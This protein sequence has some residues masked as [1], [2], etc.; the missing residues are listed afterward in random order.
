MGRIIFCTCQGKEEKG[1]ALDEL[2]QSGNE[3][4]VLNDLCGLAVEKPAQ[5]RELFK[6]HGKVVLIACHARAVE[7]I[8]RFAELEADHFPQK[9]IDRKMENW[10]LEE[11]EY[12]GKTKPEGKPVEIQ[13]LNHSDWPSWYPVLDTT[14]CTSCGQCADFCLFG[15]YKKGDGWIKV[16][17]PQACKNNCPAC[18]RIC[19]H[20]AIIFPKYQFGGAISGSE[21]INEEAEMERQRKDIANFLGSDIYKG[22]EQRKAK[23]QMIIKQDALQK[24]LSERDKAL[25]ETEIKNDGKPAADSVNL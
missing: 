21:E 10:Q 25:R 15:V 22:L 13:N 20:I 1:K 6:H 19:P 9:I 14:R 16:V 5:L 23:R 12:F 18:A 11:S 24:A 17:N 3:I 7:N 2:R 8:L 4:I